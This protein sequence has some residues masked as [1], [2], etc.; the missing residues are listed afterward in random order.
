MEM[1]SPKHPSK[2]DKAI[3]HQND[4]ALLDFLKGHFEFSTD[5]KLATHVGLTRH[6]VYKVRTGDVALGNGIRLRLLENSGQFRQFIPLPDL[7]AKSL[8]DGIKNRLDD[9]A[10]PEKP[11]V[12]GLISDAEL[13]A[14][15]KQHIAATTDEAVAGKIGLKRTS[16]SMLRKGMAK[17]GIAPRIQIAGVLYPD[18][19]IA[20]LET[21]INDSGELAQFLQTMPPNT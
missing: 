10:E 11:S 3:I 9:A 12:G 13:L 16:L 19:D 8:L 20:K 18:A 1:V 7:S 15:F 5:V 2:P 17:F 21:L 14:C 6:A 4:V